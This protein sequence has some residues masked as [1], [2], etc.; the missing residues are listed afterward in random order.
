MG[1]CLAVA[2]TN[3][4]GVVSGGGGNCLGIGQKNYQAS[5]GIKGASLREIVVDPNMLIPKLRAVS[6]AMV[7]N[8]PVKALLFACCFL[9]AGVSASQASDSLY[10]K[11]A[12]VDPSPGL[13][14][15]FGP[16]AG[17]IRYDRRM[18][19]AAQI[20]Q[21]RARKHSVASC[22]RYVKNALLQASVVDSRPTSVYAKQ[23]GNELITKFGFKRIPVKDP[24]KAPIGAILVYGG[25]GAG[26][27]EFRT[28][29]GF[30]SD[31]AS[32]TPSRR[33]LLGVYVKPS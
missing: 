3:C 15:L 26:H 33:P 2:S 28:K 1:T 23:A 19:Q 25:R 4:G 20:A 27:V 22:W 10:D 5:V 29:T 14:S 17:S 12:A 32:R 24:Y 6:F 16:K 9:A 31:F 30:V 21:E 8:S 7:E 11:N 18:I 13:I